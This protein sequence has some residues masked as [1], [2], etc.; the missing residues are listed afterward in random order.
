[1]RIWPAIDLCGGKC[2]RL[3]QGDFGHKTTYGDD[4]AAMARR[5]VEAGAAGLHLVDLDGAREGVPG[6]LPAIEAILQAVKVPC[7][8]GGGIREEETI[9]QLL[10]LGAGRVIV[11]T[12]ALT[13]PDWFRA[14]VERFPGRLVLGVDARDGWVAT[15]GWL[16]TARVRALDLVRPLADLPLAAVCYTDIA[17]D[18]MLQGPNLGAME[19]MRAVWPGELIASGG[20]T[21]ADDVRALAALGVD[22]CIIG[23]ALY[24]GR[25]ELPEA[26]AA[27]AP[28]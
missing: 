21:T 9:R 23:R 6:N 7:Q 5:W 17:R 8:V 11:G 28:P 19:A 16:Q 22:G 4:P 27:A 26:L 13:D 25:L 15:D 10:A 14:M 12:R 3:R 18:G 2:V 24:E 1:M 20:V